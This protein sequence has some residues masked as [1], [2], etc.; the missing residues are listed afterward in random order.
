LA[1]ILFQIGPGGKVKAWTGFFII[2]KIPPFPKVG[3]F[4]LVS[5]AKGPFGKLSLFFG[6]LG[7]KGHY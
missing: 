4:F 5:K 3:F 1:I 7:P 6:F 2:G